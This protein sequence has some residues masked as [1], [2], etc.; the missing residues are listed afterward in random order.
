MVVGIAVS[1]CFHV[2]EMKFGCLL[3]ANSFRFSLDGWVRLRN[4]FCFHIY[5]SFN[6]PSFSL[7]IHSKILTIFAIV[8]EICALIWWVS[9]ADIMI[10]IL[11]KVFYLSILV[12]GVGILD[13]TY[14][15]TGTHHK[16]IMFGLG[17]KRF[18]SLKVW[19]F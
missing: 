19:P 14:H 13:R 2:L 1:F 17:L 9:F 16:V 3:W 18:G 8:C 10:L 15:L 11:Y 6:F 4:H 7:Q 12:V 5:G